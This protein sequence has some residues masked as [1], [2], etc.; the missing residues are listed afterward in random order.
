MVFGGAALAIVGVGILG[1]IAMVVARRTR[2]IGI[3]MALGA[4]WSNVVGMV[5]R[6]QF[7]SI[8]AGVACGALSCC[9]GLCNLGDVILT[10]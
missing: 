4:A 6:E 7:R 10:R 9:S 1:A 5:L 3:R 2:E 8:A